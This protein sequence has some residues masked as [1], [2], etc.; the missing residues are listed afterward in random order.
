MQDDSSGMIHNNNQMMISENG[1]NTT[2]IA[3]GAL[4]HDGEPPALRADSNDQ[5]FHHKANNGE[6]FPPIEPMMMS[7]SAKTRF[8][9]LPSADAGGLLPPQDPLENNCWSPNLVEFT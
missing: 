1:P 3:S 2:S 6:F 8:M 4:L 5:T 9:Q 7:N